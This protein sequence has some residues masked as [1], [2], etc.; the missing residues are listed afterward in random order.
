M[1]SYVRASPAVAALAGVA[2]LAGCGQGGDTAAASPQAT[3]VSTA[4]AGTSQA[5]AQGAA[6]TQPGVLRGS[7]AA[8]EGADVVVRVSYANGTVT[9]SPGVVQVD[10]GQRV[11]VDITSDTHEGIRV[12][13]HPDESGDVDPGD[14]EGVEFTANQTGDF[15]V[16]LTQDDVVLVTISVR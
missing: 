4:G 15:P 1:N 16:T 2:L 3:P 10:L 12:A 8:A 6:T 14:P 9:P 13:G 11:Q 5:A 7:A